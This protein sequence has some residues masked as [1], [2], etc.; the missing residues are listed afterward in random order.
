M[1]RVHQL[2]DGGVGLGDG[3]RLPVREQV[4]LVDQQVVADPVFH[5]DPPIAVHHAPPGG[6]DPHGGD[7]VVAALLVIGPALDDLQLVKRHGGDGDQHHRDQD[8]D[9]HP[10]R[11][12]QLIHT[13]SFIRF[14]PAMSFRSGPPAEGRNS[15]SP[16]R[17]TAFAAK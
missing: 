16:L 1:D 15:Y 12:D 13:F 5:Q 17:A 10:H 4:L 6:G 7:H 11:F 2:Q 8:H 14:S 9:R 3:L